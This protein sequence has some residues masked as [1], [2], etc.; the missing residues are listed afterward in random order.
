M[1]NDDAPKR[2][3]GRPE[4]S[5]NRMAR[6][7]REAAQKTGKLPHEILLDMARGKPIHVPKVDK[8]GN[9]VVDDDGVI[10]GHWLVPQTLDEIRSAAVAAAPYFAPKITA[11]EV[12][13]GASEDELDRIIAQF[14][15]EAGIGIG[16]SVQG[17]SGEEEAGGGTYGDADRTPQRSGPGSATV[18]RKRPVT[19]T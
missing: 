4:G 6:E 16:T 9:V 3:R 13:S 8:A 11:V 14:A 12:L 7:A 15:A 5:A 2:G 19:G 18:L 10:Q 17:T 1:E